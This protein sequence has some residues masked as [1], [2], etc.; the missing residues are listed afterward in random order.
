MSFR[1]SLICNPVSSG[2]DQFDY[3]KIDHKTSINAVFTKFLTNLQKTGKKVRI[4]FIDI[5]TTFTSVNTSSKK[6]QFIYIND[7]TD[8]FTF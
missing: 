8:L 4:G 1:C 2:W 7:N 6:K 3:C 5:S